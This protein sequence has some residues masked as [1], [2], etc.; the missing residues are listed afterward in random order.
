MKRCAVCKAEETLT[1]ATALHR[2]TQGGAVFVAELPGL[3]CSA[4]GESFTG[5]SWLSAF[6]REIAKYFALHGPTTG[7]TLKYMQRAGLGMSA[8]EL[9]ELISVDRTTIARWVNGERPL[10]RTVWALVA[11]MVL[12]ESGAAPALRERLRE[13]HRDRDPQP[14]EVRVEVRP[15]DNARF[16]KRKAASHD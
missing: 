5:G 12:E 13:A 4:C 14:Q 2:R 10:D 1:E 7:E 6:E 15:L 9:A 3:T 8:Q 11:A 16:M